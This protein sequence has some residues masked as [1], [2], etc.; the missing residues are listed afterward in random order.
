LQGISEDLHPFS[1]LTDSANN[2]AILEGKL[3][4]R[5]NCLDEIAQAQGI[6]DKRDTVAV[7]GRNG[8]RA[9]V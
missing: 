5:A 3:S 6:T 2:A 9:I 8:C 1:L 4:K 7:E